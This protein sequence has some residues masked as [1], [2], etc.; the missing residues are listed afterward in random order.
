M[1]VP[2]YG[3]EETPLWIAATS[4]DFAKQTIRTNP[5]LLPSQQSK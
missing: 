5:S 2:H 3:I 1:E 4:G